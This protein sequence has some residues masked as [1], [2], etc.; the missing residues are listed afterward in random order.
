MWSKCVALTEQRE[1]LLTRLQAGRPALMLRLPLEAEAGAGSVLREFAEVA[2]AQGCIW[3]R[4]DAR[5][6]QPLAQHRCRIAR[7][8]FIG[9]IGAHRGGFQSMG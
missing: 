2:A 4:A 6:T 9:A 5:A 1:L 3:A 7:G 8:E